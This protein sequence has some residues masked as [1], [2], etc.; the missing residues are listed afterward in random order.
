MQIERQPE[1]SARTGLPRSQLYRLIK[2][3]DFPRPVKLGGRAA[4]W[5]SSE[6]DNWIAGRVKERD[7]RTPRGVREP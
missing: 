3:G 7:A 2:E 6:I 1:V 5:L 4:G